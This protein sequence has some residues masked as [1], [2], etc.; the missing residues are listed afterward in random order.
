MID[1]ILAILIYAGL[2]VAIFI[3]F[4]IVAAAIGTALKEGK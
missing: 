2:V 3:L 4:L 1:T